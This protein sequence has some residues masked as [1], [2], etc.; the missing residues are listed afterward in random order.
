MGLRGPA[1]KPTALRLLEGNTRRPP[2]NDR[3][4]RPAPPRC[5]KHLDA[6]ARREWRRLVRILQRM[7]DV[8]EADGFAMEILC[9]A[10]STLIKA[11]LRL[12]ETGLL[13]ETSLGYVKQ[14]PLL[15]I[16]D[17]CMDT[18]TKL[19]LEFGLTPA[20]PSRVRLQ[21]GPDEEASDPI[22]DALVGP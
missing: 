10:H 9:Q 7:R 3:E 20:S 6:K 21:A 15:G 11:Q 18:I 22:M 8:T 13:L 1:P 2:V 14:N 17:H 5:P 4:P 19:S 12:S 16:V